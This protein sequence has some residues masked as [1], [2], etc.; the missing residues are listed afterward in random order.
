MSVPG[1]PAPPP[2]P[3]PRPP[4]QPKQQGIRLRPAFIV[5]MVFL[6]V[7]VG[8]VVG[9]VTIFASGMAVAAEVTTEPISTAGANP[10][11][12][13]VGTD[14]ANVTPPPN[15]AGSFPANTPGLYGGTL[16]QASCDAAAMVAFLQANP[17]KA[18]A[19]A[20]SLGIDV[21][22]IPTYVAEL[23]PV[24]LRTDTWVTNHG[25]RDGKA[26]PITAVLQ[27]GTAVLVD[28]FGQPRVKCYCGNPLKPVVVPSS[29]QFIGPSW[30]G[31]SDTNITIIQETTVVINTFTLVNPLT[32]EVFERPAGSSGASDKPVSGL[33][34][35]GT[36]APTTAPAPQART[37]TGEHTLVQAD[38][39]NC[40]FSDAPQI[41]GTITMNVQPN[42]AVTGTMRGKGSGSRQITC[43]DMSAT[44]NWSQ[45]YTVSFTGQVVNDRFTASGTLSNVN[46][47]RLTNCT[48]DGQAVACP[49]Y[50]GGPGSLPIRLDGTYNLATGQG[51]GTF[52][53]QV[54]RPTTGNWSVG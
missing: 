21:A 22:A 4:V 34:S 31:F 37:S 29:P 7:V 23:T 30:P 10:F 32:N 48:Q 46:R 19:W 50:G 49:A 27:A 40:S 12:P 20:A 9:I 44:M 17:D 2:G 13:P 11:M 33:P 25:F 36:A 52:A 39:S 26:N 41:N 18:A 24:I 5:S 38:A 8:A 45:D 15:T 35:S 3:P 6:L 1:V 14:Q 54:E 28:K 43:G 16:N 47:T 42:G 51:S 53:V